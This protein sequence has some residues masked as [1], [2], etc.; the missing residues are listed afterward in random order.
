M[1]EPTPEERVAELEDDWE[2]SHDQGNPE[3][4]MADL[5]ESFRAAVAAERERCARIAYIKCRTIGIIRL[6]DDEQADE[7]GCQIFAA[8]RKDPDE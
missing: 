7:A 4:L 1:S 3:A 8:I 6:F 5:L 2:I